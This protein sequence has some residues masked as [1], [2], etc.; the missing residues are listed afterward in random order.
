MKRSLA[1]SGVKEFM[2]FLMNREK[3]AVILSIVDDKLTFVQP[4]CS[5]VHGKKHWFGHR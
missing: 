2:A 5:A 3:D 1:V 4:D